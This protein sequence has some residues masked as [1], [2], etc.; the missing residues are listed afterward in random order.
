MSAAHPVFACTCGAAWG[1]VEGPCV[2]DVPA[3]MIG[4]K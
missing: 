2:C 3:H 1:T 4:G